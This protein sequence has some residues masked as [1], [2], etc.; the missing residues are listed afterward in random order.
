VGRSFRDFILAMAF[1][2]IMSTNLSE[3][4]EVQRL[5][6]PSLNKLEAAGRRDI[7]VR[8]EPSTYPCGKFRFRLVDG[9]IITTGIHSR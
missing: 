8:M 4:S 3:G 1:L 7:I 5:A 6:I 9:E 2:E